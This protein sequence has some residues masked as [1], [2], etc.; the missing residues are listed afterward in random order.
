M[1]AL[2]A[3]LIIAAILLAPAPAA[4]DVMQFKLLPNY[5]RAVFKTDAPLETVQGAALPAGL[6][7]TL[8][9][10]PATPRDAR[11]SVRV[12]MSQVRTGIEKRDADMLLPG[13]LHVAA[14]DAH[15]YVTFEVRN[16]EIA[17]PLV[18]GQNAPARVAGVLTVKNRPIEVV[19]E[20]TVSYFRLTPEQVEAQK[21]FGFQSDNVKVRARLET[22]FTKHG[23]QVPQLLFL[24][25]SDEIQIE[26]DLV[27]V[28]GQ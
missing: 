21:R 19:A 25:V 13:F 12:D 27:F 4:A 10:D 1:H 5:S 18:A 23:M 6:A 3:S 26:A 9:L 8:T 11:G 7:G 2:A 16:V 15:R 14:N 22:A 20:A 28:R 17:G 24:K